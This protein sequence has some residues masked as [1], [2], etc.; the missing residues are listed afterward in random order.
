M[1]G[2]QGRLSM[3]SILC[4]AYYVK[5]IMAKDQPFRNDNVRKYLMLQYNSEPN[6]L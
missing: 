5:K 3:I 4:S 1:N 2:A 6:H